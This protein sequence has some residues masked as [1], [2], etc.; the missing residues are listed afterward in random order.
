MHI[1]QHGEGE[2]QLF[3]DIH[4]LSGPEFDLF[5]AQVTDARHNKNSGQ[6][7]FEFNASDPVVRTVTL[8]TREEARTAGIR[9]LHPDV[10]KAVRLRMIDA[11]A[12]NLSD[13]G[14]R[15]VREALATEHDV[16]YVQVASTGAHILIKATDVISRYQLTISGTEEPLTRNAFIDA[17]RMSELFELS[18]IC[19]SLNI[20]DQKSLELAISEY[21]S[22]LNG[23][24]ESDLR[25]YLA[26]CEKEGLITPRMQVVSEVK[27][28]NPPS[29]SLD[30]DYL[31]VSYDFAEKQEWRAAL[32][33]Y[34]GEFLRGRD[35]KSVRVLCLPSENPER[36]AQIYLNLGIPPENIYGVEG[37]PVLQPKF[38]AGCK[39]LGIHHITGDLQEFLKGTDLK[40]DI[41]SLDF[42]GPL[43]ERSLG[44]IRAVRVNPEAAFLVNLLAKREK[45]SVID[46]FFQQVDLRRGAE[47]LADAAKSLQGGT[48]LRE[49]R[50]SQLVSRIASALRTTEPAQSDD[51]D[52]TDER[53]KLLPGILVEEVRASHDRRDEAQCWLMSKPMGA[54]ILDILRREAAQMEQSMEAMYA[55]LAPF[56]GQSLPGGLTGDMNMFMKYYDI[57]KNIDTDSA[58][59]DHIKVNVDV[60]VSIAAHGLLGFYNAVAVQKGDPTIDKDTLAIT[61]NGIC[62]NTWR[63]INVTTVSYAS[64]AS[65]RSSPFLSVFFTL[66]EAQVGSEHGNA[67]TL[68]DEIVYESLLHYKTKPAENLLKPA[69]PAYGPRIT[70]FKNRSATGWNYRVGHENRGNV[71]AEALYALLKEQA[72][73]VIAQ[74]SKYQITGSVMEHVSI[75]AAA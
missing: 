21:R 70:P 46:S 6:L 22:Q 38:I 44:A 35:P 48:A 49:D 9:T 59:R 53:K 2:A 33:S 1:E 27:S 23:L 8:P 41:V 19:E 58:L 69:E 32:G 75:K 67:V 14:L 28:E 36:E 40:F 34:V 71:D 31:G 25:E 57:T 66:T 51:V 73:P 12:D 43:S 37:N 15:G 16:P 24:A 50:P 17:Y 20:S 55:I 18:E 11:Y 62:M 39:A 61:L 47:R 54:Q 30:S 65:T 63:A 52:L 29:P 72:Q 64:R 74:M 7:A 56:K 10:A 4:A 26:S 13:E 5:L 68:V 3:R 42:M 45:S 60:G